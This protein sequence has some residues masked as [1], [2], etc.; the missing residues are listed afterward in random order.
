MEGFFYFYTMKKYIPFVFLALYFFTYTIGQF[1]G[2][3]DRLAPQFVFLSILNI[4]CLF[5]FIWNRKFDH[6]IQSIKL[7]NYLLSYLGFISICGFSII[8]ANNKIEAIIIFAEMLTF[9]F[10]FINIYLIAISQKKLFIDFLIVIIIVSLLVEIYP[11]ISLFYE[12][13]TLDSNSFKRSNDYRGLSGNINIS[14]FS[15]LYKI[16]ILF[17]LIL[18]KNNFYIILVSLILTFISTSVL[19]IL[20]SRGAIIALFL[21]FIIL[22]ISTLY[23]KK[24]IYIIKSLFIAAAIV[25]SFFLTSNYIS[26]ISDTNVVAERIERL[27]DGIED[28][29]FAQRSRYFSH[30]I[31]SIIKYP[32]LGVGIGN[33]K[34]ESI[35]YD[36]YTMSEY[37]VPFYAHNDF[38]QLGAEIGLVGLVFFLYFLLGTLWEVFKK[39]KKKENFPFMIFLFLSLI[40]FII[41]ATINFPTFRPISHV[42]LL[43]LVNMCY[44]IIN[45]KYDYES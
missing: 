27:G 9:M 31:Q 22:F 10:V 12:N 24:K 13:S 45:N 8:I 37:F 6:I 1:M 17:Y 23:V 40:S 14:A 34:V 25:S 44:V 29:S 38:L 16:P 26:S 33:W 36:A 2:A 11:S 21:T 7:N 41:D 35:K 28:E 42:F 20:L 4:I 43:F 15:I 5:Y 3:W 19:V 30:A 39:I 32:L 18:R